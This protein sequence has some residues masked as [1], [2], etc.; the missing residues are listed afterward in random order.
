MA[1][2][3]KKELQA[4]NKE[5]EVLSK[6]VDKIAAGIGKSKKAKP[7]ASAKKTTKDAA[8]K[9]IVAPKK[10][11]SQTE[12]EATIVV[13]SEAENGIDEETYAKE[14]EINKKQI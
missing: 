6:K 3:M 2:N 7:T 10:S 14:T 12:S 13:I 9:N 11:T 1:I 4:I 5:L 8:T